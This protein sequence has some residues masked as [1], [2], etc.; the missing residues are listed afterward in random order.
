MTLSVIVEVVVN[1]CLTGATSLRNKKMRMSLGK[2]P[3]QQQRLY[4]RTM[5]MPVIMATQYIPS[6]MQTHRTTKTHME[7]TDLEEE[8][9]GTQIKD[10]AVETDLHKKIHIQALVGLLLV[11]P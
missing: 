3:Q 5:I 10:T 4:A 8:V 11:A 7:L 6:Q 1:M 9:V 2:S